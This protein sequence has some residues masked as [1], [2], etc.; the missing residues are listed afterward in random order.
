L[1]IIDGTIVELMKKVPSYQTWKWCNTWLFLSLSTSFP[2]Q[3][4]NFFFGWI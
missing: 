1:D 3:S 2:H 4:N